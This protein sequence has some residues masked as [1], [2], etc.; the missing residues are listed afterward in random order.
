MGGNAKTLMFVCCSPSDYNSSEST[1]SLDFAKRC[2]NV[3]NNV[4]GGGTMTTNTGDQGQIKALKAE[5]ARMK[6]QNV[7]SKKK[8]T[9]STH[10]PRRPGLPK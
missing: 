3:T 4:K 1:N 2:K 10:I 9:G 5:L 7:S 6:K 8:K